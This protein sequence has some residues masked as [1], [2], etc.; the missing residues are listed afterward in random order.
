MLPRTNV[1]RCRDADY[2]LFA[3]TDLISTALYLTDGWEPHL[4]DISRVFHQAATRPLVLDIG[5]NLGAYAV[6]VA[7]EIQARGGV[8]YAYEPQRIVY[9]QL[10]GNAV[11]N[12]LD[13]LLAYNNAVGDQP[14]TVFIPDMDL[15]R[16]PN[17]GGFSLVKTY[18]EAQGVES[19]MLEGGHH[20]PMV[21]LDDLDLPASPCVI[22]ID[23]EGYELEVLQGGLKF[24]E[25]HGYPP[26]LFEAWNR[27]WYA[28][29]KEALLRLIT[30]LGYRV[31]TI[32]K[33]NFIAQHPSHPV[34][35]E[36]HPL[37]SDQ[38]EVRRLR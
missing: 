9:Y 16:Q 7:K 18:R 4:V 28:P 14:C 35:I 25:H 5:A 30:S 31:Q 10:C 15:S 17:V 1:I 34:Q 6:P 8:V 32:L 21:A 36:I 12:R 2:L 24:L 20:V 27:E 19:A 37:G 29:Q 13:N 33:D 38:L 23:V 26:F 22:K 3:T 11:L